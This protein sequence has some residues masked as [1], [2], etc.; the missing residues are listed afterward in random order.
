MFTSHSLQDGNTPNVS[1]TIQN[2]LTAISYVTSSA[3]RH[4]LSFYYRPCNDFQIY[5]II[6]I[7]ITLNELISQLL[8]DDLYSSR[9]HIY[10]NNSF[11]FYF[12][13]PNDQRIYKVACE[14]ISH[15][16]IVQY[17]NSNIC[18]IE[19]K[20]SEQQQQ[21][22]PLEFSNKHKE[23]LEFHLRQSLIDNLTSN[24]N[25]GHGMS[26]SSYASLVNIA[27]NNQQEYNLLHLKTI[28][29]TI[30]KVVAITQLNDSIERF[31]F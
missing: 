23:N 3:S 10:S 28:M 12:Q 26:S 11:V 9:N 19:L 14:M 18:G 27:N 4:A 6:C 17:L 22:Q 7:E 29:R 25:V 20:Q 30:F 8:I 31:L 16:I 5:L 1:S 13:H 15:S 2:T 24:I 21:Q